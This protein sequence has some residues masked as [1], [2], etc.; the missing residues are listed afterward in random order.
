MKI[1][2]DTHVFIWWHND[3]KKLS[4]TAF[5]MIKD[6]E[7]M[8]FLS[9]VSIWEMQIKLQLGKLQ[10]QVSL[11]LLINEQQTKNGLHIL[12]IALEHILTLEKLPS[13][14]QD[15][16]DRL[17][18]AQS[19]YEKMPIITHDNQFSNYPISTLW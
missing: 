11:P 1:L 14:H 18:I 8:L 9:M 5:T 16:F 12:P 17:L 3:S 13:H 6:K 4:Q 2:L 15:P 7:N 10:L 19:I